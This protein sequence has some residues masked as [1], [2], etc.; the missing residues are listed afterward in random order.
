MR[1]GIHTA[2]SV[3]SGLLLGGCVT[4]APVATIQMAPIG[5]ASVQAGAA[6]AEA[7][8][9]TKEQGRQLVTCRYPEFT[10]SA[11]GDGARDAYLTGVVAQY[12]IYDGDG[13]AEVT[14]SGGGRGMTYTLSDLIFDVTTADA[15][16]GRRQVVHIEPLSQLTIACDSMGRTQAFEVKGFA[17][18]ALVMSLKPLPLAVSSPMLRCSSG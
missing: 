9:L 13:R 2:T 6:Q 18:A 5:T 4:T 12:A 1:R 3:V 10:F 17:S 14:I 8:M 16:G 11:A 15:G 7:C